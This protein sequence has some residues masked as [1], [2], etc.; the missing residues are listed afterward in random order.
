[1]DEP[2]D[3]GAVAAY[4]KETRGL[5]Y[6]DIPSNYHSNWMDNTRAKFELE[7][8][9]RYDLVRLIDAAW[10]LPA[11]ARRSPQ[12]V[13]SR[14]SHKERTSRVRPGCLTGLM[15]GRRERSAWPLN[16]ASGLPP[17]WAN[18]NHPRLDDDRS[19]AA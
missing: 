4:L 2:V 7:W 16:V 10:N 6:L 17:E 5:D 8:R 15:D 12:R 9:P 1:M 19:R 18:S 11:R 14:L 3:Y 13:V